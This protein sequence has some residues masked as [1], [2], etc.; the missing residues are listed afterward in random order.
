M[1]HK[2]FAFTVPIVSFW[3]C[4]QTP[5]NNI[6]TESDQALI[7]EVFHLQKTLGS[8]V[9]TQ[10]QAEGKPFMLRSNGNH[11]L[12]NHPNPPKEF[13]QLEISNFKQSILWKPSEN[14]QPIEASY[15]ING[16]VTV[17][18]S[19]PSP[20]GSK[21]EWVL[22]A[23][24][25]LFHIYQNEQISNALKKLHDFNSDR[26]SNTNELDFPYPFYDNNVLA[27][28]RLEAEKTFQL[29]K[30]DS[31]ESI[32]KKQQRRFADVLMITNA[33][34]QDSLYFKYKSH[35]EWK[36]GV[37]RYTEQQIAMLALDNYQ[38]SKAF[39]KHFPKAD[40]TTLSD[41]YIYTSVI[42]PIQFVGEGVV[43]RVIF[44]YSGMGKAY[45]LDKLKPDWKDSYFDQTLDAL[46][47]GKKQ[48]LMC[49]QQ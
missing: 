32:A 3:L 39:L 28:Q 5:S 42:A 35:M 14:E 33:V 25:E 34:L 23:V 9:W 21:T 41:R 10:W 6:F 31:L 20:E 45:L 27:I 7:E 30:F 46:I 8:K 4:A 40:Y 47:I 43:G 48:Y 36:E 13:T 22:K 24:H 18:M 29:L 26:F 44:Y 17:V 38:P 12:I 2:C 11:I 49:T 37:A 19:A 16:I 15:P 1:I